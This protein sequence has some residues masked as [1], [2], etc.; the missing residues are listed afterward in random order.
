MQRT[1]TTAQTDPVYV[2]NNHDL[3]FLNNVAQNMYESDILEA[4]SYKFSYIADVISIQTGKIKH[5][6]VD[7]IPKKLIR[8]IISN[9]VSEVIKML[10]QVFPEY[11][12]DDDSSED[13]EITEEMA[14]DLKAAQDQIFALCE[15]T[16]PEN[17]TQEGADEVVEIYFV[18]EFSGAELLAMLNYEPN[19]YVH[20]LTE[21]LNIIR[22]SL[23]R[24]LPAEL[25][26]T[27][28]NDYSE[29]SYYAFR[30][31]FTNFFPQHGPQ[32]YCTLAISN[33]CICERIHKAE[34]NLLKLR[35]P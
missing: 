18:N 16:E 12:I 11:Y 31:Y 33:Y 8:K 6:L 13:L 1:N 25:I 24:K 28:V 22:G 27:I 30:K 4:V 20:I 3:V 7:K 23:H 26:K 9:Y 19:R 10:R 15:L 32:K 17:N 29:E 35:I 14:D 34:K 5:L 2:K 21:Q